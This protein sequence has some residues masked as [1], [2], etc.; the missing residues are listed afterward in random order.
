MKARPSYCDYCLDA[1]EP[2]AGYAC[3]CKGWLAA[4]CPEPEEDEDETEIP[5]T[6]IAA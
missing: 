6:E 5:A 2:S 1:L 3:N 4:N